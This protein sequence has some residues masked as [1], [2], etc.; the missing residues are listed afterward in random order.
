MTAARQTEHQI[1]SAFVTIDVNEI[2]SPGP[3]FRELIFRV[4]RADVVEVYRIHISD[5]EL[6]KAPYDAKQYLLTYVQFRGQPPLFSYREA[7]RVRP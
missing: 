1:G 7:P 2:S 5:Q 4:R 3:E 6:P